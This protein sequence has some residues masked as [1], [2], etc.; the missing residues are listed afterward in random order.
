MIKPSIL[1]SPRKSAIP[2][3][4]CVLEVLVR[5]QAPDPSP[6]TQDK[7]IPKRLALVVDRSGSMDGQPL[8]EALNCILHIANCMT[9]ADQMSIVVYDDKVKVL[10]PLSPMTSAEAIRQA[11]AQVESGGSTDLFAGWQAGVQQLEVGV[12]ESISR[13]LLLSDGQANH[14]LCSGD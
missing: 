7:V 1:L 11:V 2:A 14:G 6:E 5:V 3:Q 10:V 8:A 9:L 13:V 4:G 12:A